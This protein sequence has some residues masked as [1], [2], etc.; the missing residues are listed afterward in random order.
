MDWEENIFWI[1][2]SEFGLIWILE[3]NP[4]KERQD[5]FSWFCLSIFGFFLMFF[6]VKKQN[7]VGYK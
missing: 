4:K 2:C 7:G 1:V 5:W 3:K 6:N